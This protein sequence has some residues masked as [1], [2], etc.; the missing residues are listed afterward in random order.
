MLRMCPKF[1]GKGGEFAEDGT[2][3]HHCLNEYLN[4]DEHAFDNYTEEQQD[5]LLWAAEYIKLKAPLADHPLICETT[6]HLIC[7][8]GEA[9]DG[10]PDATCGNYVFDLKWRYRNYRPQMAAYAL[11]LMQE[12][13]VDHATTAALFAAEGFHKAEVETWTP[14]KAWNAIKD[15]IE[16]VL[17]PDAQ[18]N[19]N[20]YCGWC[21][22]TLN[23]DGKTTCPALIDRINGVIMGREDWKLQQYHASEMKDGKELGKALRIARALKDWC[24]A[25]EHF[26]REV[27]EKQGIMIEGFEWKSRRGNR[28]VADLTAAYPLLGIPQEHFLKSCTMSPRKLFDAYAEV[29]GLKKTAAER[30]VENKLGEIIQRKPTVAVLSAIKPPKE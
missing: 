19:P 4:G 15:I 3:R 13:S 10:T 22:H 2:I 29:H 21:Q 9:M 8:N 5:G 25:V 28:Y 26:A 23:E 1:R 24:A 27:G 6:G 12:R 16:G 30:E 20:D 14:E 18:E 11:M 7:P 17:A